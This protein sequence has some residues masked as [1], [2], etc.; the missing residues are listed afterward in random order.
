M[1]IRGDSCEQKSYGATIRNK[2][3]NGIKAIYFVYY[4]HDCPERIISSGI[5]FRNH[6]MHC[7]S[8]KINKQTKN[9]KK[10]TV[11]EL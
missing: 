3:W 6:K 8:V 5:G 9:W 7:F 11:L 2:Q 1:S 10:N 4:L